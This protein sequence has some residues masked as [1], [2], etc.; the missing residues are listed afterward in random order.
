MDTT[1]LKRTGYLLLLL[2]VFVLLF[3]TIT[4]Y[5]YWWLLAT[6]IG[7]GVLFLYERLKPKATSSEIATQ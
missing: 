2:A 7:V 4:R 3:L 6:I 1:K 5:F